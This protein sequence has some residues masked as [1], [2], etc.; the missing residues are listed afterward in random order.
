M[1]YQE[2]INTFEKKNTILKLKRKYFRMFCMGVTLL[3]VLILTNEPAIS[4]WG[5]CFG[6]LLIAFLLWVFVY[7]FQ[8]R[9]SMRR[10]RTIMTERNLP[11]VRKINDKTS[12]DE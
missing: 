11:D 9:D 2:A 1:D 5:T 4:F 3:T 8:R 7:K 10:L 12:D 6:Y